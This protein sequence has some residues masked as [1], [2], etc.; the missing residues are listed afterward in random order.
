MA[1]K[2]FEIASY[3]LDVFGQTLI[4]YNNQAITIYAIVRAKGK[5]GELFDILVT[6]NWQELP[7]YAEI[8]GTKV[9]GQIVV[10]PERYA[11]FVDLIRNEGHI[12]AHVDSSAPRQNH[13]SAGGA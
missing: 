10:A 8:S 13:L 12:Y 2:G 6:P 3:E 1:T 7:P 5:D 9:V 11:W 4:T